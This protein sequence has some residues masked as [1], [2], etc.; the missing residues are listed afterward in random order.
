MVVVSDWQWLASI[1]D[2]PQNAPLRTSH[3]PIMPGMKISIFSPEFFFSACPSLERKSRTGCAVCFNVFNLFASVFYLQFMN[4]A[5]FYCH[6]LRKKSVCGCITS[7]VVFIPTNV[8]RRFTG[9]GLTTVY[10]FLY[11]KQTK[12]S[13][14]VQ[15]VNKHDWAR[16]AII[17]GNWLCYT[18][19]AVSSNSDYLLM[20]SLF[21]WAEKCLLRSV[22]ISLEIDIRVAGQSWSVFNL[23][24]ASHHKMYCSTIDRCTRPNLNFR[25]YL[26]SICFTF[27]AKSEVGIEKPG[28]WIA[29]DLI[30]HRNT[31]MCIFQLFY[32]HR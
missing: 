16:Q 12:P 27:V 29:C 22:L 13:T 10:G 4:G 24:V 30:W 2:W 19:I 20:P 1:L 5:S 25:F 28:T 15:F 32:F 14:E 21:E 18:F 3:T 9:L 6:K 11:D 26:T 8:S 17:T 7:S 31:V 23:F